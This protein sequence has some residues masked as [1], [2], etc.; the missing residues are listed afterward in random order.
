MGIEH[1]KLLFVLLG[2]AFFING[3]AYKNEWFL[4]PK[5]RDK[6]HPPIKFRDVFGA[7]ALYLLIQVVVAPNLFVLYNYFYSGEWVVPRSAEQGWIG[8][9]AGVSSTLGLV[10]FCR[11]VGPRITWILA[12]GSWRKF[13]G[14]VAWALLSWLASFPV[15]S[16]SALVAS[17]VLS[18]FGLST[19]VDQVAVKLIKETRPVP[20]LFWAL[21][22]LVI[23]VIP[24]VEEVI[25]RG[26]LQ[27]WLRQKM[28]AK[29]AIAV[30]SIVFAGF[31]FSAS[32]GWH[33]VDLF[34]AL[35][36]LS[37]YM[38]LLFEKRGSIWA[39][40]SLHMTFN[41]ISEIAIILQEGGF[42]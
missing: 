15:M 19:D 6:I 16:I 11:L 35:F 30:A 33:N 39:P 5:G 4:L 2:W 10:F 13:F 24:F 36:V 27:S 7:F 28:P 40:V 21:F 37:C 31:H 12:R 17:S 25:F 8:I 18:Y 41:A 42:P 1:M 38:G 22:F 26:F 3:I 29:Q 14:D 23:F 34:A 20:I 32:Q 9:I